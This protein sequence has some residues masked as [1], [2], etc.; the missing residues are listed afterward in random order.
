[1]TD[2]QLA[3]VREALF[4]LAHLLTEPFFFGFAT[5]EERARETQPSI[6]ARRLDQR[7]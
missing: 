6:D 3:H 7:G 4:V 5:L 1:L 2:G